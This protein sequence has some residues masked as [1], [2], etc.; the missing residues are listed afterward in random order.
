MNTIVRIGS[1][2][3]EA[4]GAR[5]CNMAGIKDVAKLAQVGGGTVSR[6][7]NENG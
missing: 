3:V 7:I 1:K 2:Y 6:V 5:R 4:T